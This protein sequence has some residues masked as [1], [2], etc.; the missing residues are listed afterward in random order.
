VISPNANNVETTAE[1]K[2]TM[3]AHSNIQHPN[4]ESAVLC[5]S[6]N[7]TPATSNI[8]FVGKQP[9]TS[10]NLLQPTRTSSII[11]S[12]FCKN[13]LYDVKQLASAC[14][15]QLC[16]SSNLYLFR[17]ETALSLQATSTYTGRNQLFHIKQHLPIQAG[18]SSSISSNLYLYRQETALSYHATST[19]P[20]RN[21]LYLLFIGNIQPLSC[22]F[23]PVTMH[24]SIITTQ[25]VCR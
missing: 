7:K 16:S 6:I 11:S 22:L 14:K 17:Q 12:N 1:T 5:L 19:Y 13:Q 9:I 3:Q 2:H 25:P 20:G 21:Q 15:N 10:S 18:N 23:N 24:P 4:W 8:F